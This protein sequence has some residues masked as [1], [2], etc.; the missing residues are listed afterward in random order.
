[1]TEKMM[2]DVCK[3]LRENGCRGVHIGGG[4]PFIE[5]D[6]LCEL[7]RVCRD[8]GISVDYVETNA[9]WANN[10]ARA[11][12]YLNALSR[13]GV[14]A[15]CISCDEYHAEYI[16]Y[17][18]PLKLAGVCRRTRYGYFLWETQLNNLRFNGRAIHLEA[19]RKPKKPLPAILN[20][21]RTLGPCKNLT[22]KNHFHIDLYG[23]YI[24]PGCTGIVLPPED[25][26]SMEYA[27]G[28][29]AFEALYNGGLTALLELAQN[30][31]FEPNPAGYPSVCACC[32]HTR[33]WLS[34][35][36]GF[37]ELDKEHYI[38]ALSI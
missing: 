16:P 24:P 20:D 29:A 8:N 36:E 38:Q 5:F 30:L 2:H 3:V 27:E 12:K 22:S 34:E 19:E 1:M 25:V 14:N 11:I 17:E 7:V 26:L 4:E 10:E 13:A 23:R 35:R 6:G 9:Y 32:F 15:L 37:P 31:G 18:L 33:K 21:A 28:Y